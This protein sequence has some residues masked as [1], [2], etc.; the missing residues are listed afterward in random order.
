[1][2]GLN[3]SKAITASYDEAVK[4]LDD[5]MKKQFDELEGDAKDGSAQMMLARLAM[6]AKEASG[7]VKAVAFVFGVT[8]AQ[9]NFDIVKM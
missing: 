6:S 1:M 9:V 5:M 8:E 3:E 2:F 4:F 7:A